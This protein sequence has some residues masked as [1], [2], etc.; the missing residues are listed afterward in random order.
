[1]TSYAQRKIDV[2]INLGEGQFGDDKGLDVTLT[3]HR[4]SAQFLY[5]GN[6]SQG[7]AHIRIYGLPLDM[8]NKL[9]GRGPFAIQQRTDTILV[10]AGD[11][12]GPMSVVYQGQIIR[13]FADFEAA[14][15]VVFNIVSLAAAV[16]SVRAVNANSYVGTIDAAVVMEEFARVMGLGFEGNDVSVMLQNP[17]YCGTMLQQVKDCAK[18]AGIEFSIELG[19]LVIY[20]RYG[21]RLLGDPVEINV[22][23]GMIG[24]PSFA[25][26]GVSVKTIFNPD[27]VLARQV[28]I[29]SSLQAACGLWTAY[30]VAHTI[31]SETPGGQWVTTI[32]CNKANI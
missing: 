19:K 4:V 28:N 24:Y 26:Q 21:S 13:A 27:L 16:N 20:N 12:V 32:N 3:G 9:S 5:A 6:H 29:T 1:M 22:E 25:S 14:P 17:Y 7:E 11:E 10:A 15:E 31:E 23:T 2:T 8:M 18:E 30:A